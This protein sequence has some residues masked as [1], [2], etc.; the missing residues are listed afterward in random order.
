MSNETILI[1]EDS[2]AN[3]K[4]IKVLLKS[5]GYDVHTAEDAEEAQAQLAK[6]HPHLILMDIQ[7]PDM[8]GLTLTGLLKANL[9]THDIIIVALTAY[10]LAGD[11]QKAL[12]AGCDGYIA[13]PVDRPVFLS[14]VRR[15]LDMVPSHVN[16]EHS[17]PSQT[18]HED[19]KG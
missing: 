1:V 2:A 16:Q 3:M 14:T 6:I 4:L 19:P 9:A 10:A 5:A 7:L 12:A 17:S 8:D 18:D 11:E 15:Y 13:K